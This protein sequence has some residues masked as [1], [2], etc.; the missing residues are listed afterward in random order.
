MHTVV[1]QGT[2]RIGI[3]LYNTAPSAAE[4]AGSLVTITFHVRPGEP[5]G[6]SP[7]RASPRSGATT[8]Q[9]LNSAVINGQQFV[10]QVDDDQGQYVLSPGIDRVIVDAGY[11]PAF[12]GFGRK[13]GYARS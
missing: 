12:K 6:V 7:R 4:Q 5:S 13:H 10:T 2:G 9:L 8:V 3:E 11:N 1:D